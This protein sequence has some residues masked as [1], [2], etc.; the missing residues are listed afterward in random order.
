MEPLRR[1]VK[2]R[3]FYI[4]GELL[5]RNFTQ[6]VSVDW[7]PLLLKYKVEQITN[8]IICCSFRNIV[9]IKS[10]YDFISFRHSQYS[11]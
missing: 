3:V 10:K 4:T 11:S 6:I 1:G 9:L 7:L 5:D 8:V 2:Y